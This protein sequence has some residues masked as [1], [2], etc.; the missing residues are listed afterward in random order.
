[1]HARL[2]VL[3]YGGRYRYVQIAMRKPRTNRLVRRVA[4]IQRLNIIRER[5]YCLIRYV[6]YNI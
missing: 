4:H 6:M 2:R 1:M 5:L 3:R